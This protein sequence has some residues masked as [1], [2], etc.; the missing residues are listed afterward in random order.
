MLITV[1]APFYNE[2]D[3]VTEFYRRLS[4]TLQKL[5]DFNFELIFIND[6]S[7]DETLPQLIK[8]QSKDNRIKLI[9]FSR[10][11]GHQAAIIAGIRHASGDA[12]IIIDSDL[13]DPP[14]LIPD[15]IQKWFDGWDVIYGKRKKR[16]GEGLIKK[17]TAYLYYRFINFLSEVEIPKDTGDFRLI[18]KKVI[19]VIKSLEEY[20]VYLRG[21]VS[22]TGFKQCAVEYIREKRYGGKSKYSLKKMLNLAFDGIT[23]FSTRP[24]RL[25]LQLGT[26]SIFVGLALVIY[27][28]VNKFIN[29]EVIIKG[30]SSLL[31]TIVFFGGIQLFTIGIIGEY[32]GKIYKE[33]KKRPLYIIKER[34]GFEENKINNS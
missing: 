7:S 13:Q 6:G 11:F 34:L 23:S 21:L 31:I 17:F 5:P 33:T 29:P 16:K 3:T 2:A 4:K 9:N 8:L 28:L 18:D 24:L 10:N 15:M 22:W 27:T 20:N 14:E 19:N 30:W 1:I 32:V 12:A 26:F 25:A